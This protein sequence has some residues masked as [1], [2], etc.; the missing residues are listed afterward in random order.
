MEQFRLLQGIYNKQLPIIGKLY[1]QIRVLDL[2]ED[3]KCY[4]FSIKAQQLFTAVEDL[5]KATA[6]S[7]E[8]NLDDTSKYHIELL[9]RMAT[10][11][12]GIRPA[13]LSDSSLKVLDKLRSFRHFIRHAYDYELDVEELKFIQQRLNINFDN[14]IEDFNRFNTFLDELAK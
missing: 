5:L 14:V 11:I 13:V 7:F 4:V 10:E 9:R 3:D 1:G 6:K 2:N 12:N 8:N